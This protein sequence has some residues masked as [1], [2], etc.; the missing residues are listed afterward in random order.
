MHTVSKLADVDLS[1]APLNSATALAYTLEMDAG[2]S[3]TFQ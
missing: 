2:I 1:H 3:V